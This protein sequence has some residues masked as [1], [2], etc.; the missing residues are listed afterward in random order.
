MPPAR[1][2]GDSQTCPQ[3]GYD[4]AGTSRAGIQRCPEC[5]WSVRGARWKLTMIRESLERA[6]VVVVI[7]AAGVVFLTV[8]VVLR[9]SAP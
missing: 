9:F 8:L 4:L 7:I 6:D 2:P 3:C 5:G 1:T